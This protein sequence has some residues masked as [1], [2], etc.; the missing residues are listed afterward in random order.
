MREFQHRNII[1]TALYSKASMI[2]LAVLCLLLL[3]SII[4]L[5]D[6]RLK[7]E[8]EREKAYQEKSVL[9][10]KL[11]KSETRLNFV[12]TPK[13]R[14]DY[15]RTTY[16]VVKAGEGVIVVY[17]ATDSPVAEVKKDQGRWYD[18]MFLLNVY[19]D[20]VFNRNS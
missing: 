11:A 4:E 8:K 15:I 1:R 18:F 14:E 20:K 16:P 12:E 17:N 9:E 3:R 19:L 7:V 6:K 13:G 2:L 5:N 10:D